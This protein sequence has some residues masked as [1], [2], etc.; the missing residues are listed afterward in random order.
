[1]RAVKYSTT[2]SYIQ[3]LPTKGSVPDLDAAPQAM[4]TTVRPQNQ[5]P[6]CDAPGASSGKIAAAEAATN[7]F[8]SM[9]I[10]V[11]PASRPVL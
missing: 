2:E 6:A 11:A 1:M 4:V 3:V 7:A 8:C 10:R 9:Y 5:A